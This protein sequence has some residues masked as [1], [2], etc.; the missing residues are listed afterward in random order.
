M[1]FDAT[2]RLRRDPKFFVP[3][4]QATIDNRFSADGKRI[5]YEDR[6]ETFVWWTHEG[7]DA[8]EEALEALNN[9]DP[10]PALHWEDG[11]ALAARDHCLDMGLGG[12]ISDV[13]TDGSTSEERALR[14]AERS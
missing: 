11:L 14:Y 7:K 8:W 3:Y 4:I 13:G 1:I 2:N 10:I 12:L 6:G 5:T 9:Q